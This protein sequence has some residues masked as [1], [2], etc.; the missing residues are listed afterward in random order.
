M[1]AMRK[2]TAVFAGVLIAAA[3]Q[4]AFAGVET[5][6]AGQHTT[7]WWSGVDG[8]IRAS[9]TVML[10]G[11]NNFHAHFVN[12]CSHSNCDQ[13][14]QIGQSQGHELSATQ[15]WSYFESFDECGVRRLGKLGVPPTPNYPY[16]V[17]YLRETSGSCPQSQFAFRQGSWSNPAVGYGF[18]SFASGIAIAETEISSVGPRE[19]INTN[20]FGTN[21]AHVYQA[22]KA[23]HLWNGTW[24]I[25]TI[26][27]NEIEAEPPFRDT[28]HQ[29]GAFKTFD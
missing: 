11:V 15:I 12:L 19:P 10:D 4:T 24:A 25:W 13:W 20:Y 16:Y 18:M 28:L 6:Y 22:S 17:S 2:V 21:D 3:P 5:F 29:W 27:T 7:S 9:G 26:A 14:V 8:Y 23:L 1:N